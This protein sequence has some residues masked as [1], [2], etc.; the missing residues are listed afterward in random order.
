MGNENNDTAVIQSSIALL[1]ERFRE[2]QRVKAMREE[3][4][5][6]KNILVES[7]K[8]LSPTMQYYEPAAASR[9]FFHPEFFLQ[10]RSPPHICLSLWP[11]PQNKQAGFRCEETPALMSLSSTKTPPK[12]GLLDKFDASATDDGDIDTS[13]HL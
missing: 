13:L 9:L 4:E 2:L 6:S 3:K 5:L 1:Q 7:T 11:N 8:Q 10:P 12:I